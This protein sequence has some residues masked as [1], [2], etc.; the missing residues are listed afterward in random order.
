M[1]FIC[2]QLSEI[3]DHKDRIKLLKCLIKKSQ[4]EIAHSKFLLNCIYVFFTR[5][6]VGCCQQSKKEVDWL[7]RAGLIAG[8]PPSGGDES[9]RFR[10]T[11]PQCSNN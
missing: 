8:L 3:G 9:T 2:L 6:S 4:E 11:Q 1:K 7:S 10:P 5:P